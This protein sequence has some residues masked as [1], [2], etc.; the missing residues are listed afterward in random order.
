MFVPDSKPAMK[1]MKLIDTHAHVYVSEFD[2][3]RQAVMEQADKAGITRILMPAIDASTHAA[4]LQA[5]EQ[6]PGQCLSMIGL[7]P[8]SVRENFM[9]ELAIVS[10]YLTNRKWVAIGETGLDYYWDLTFREQQVQSF[11]VQIDWAREFRLPLVI[12]S[13]NSTD[14]CVEMIRKNQGGDLTGVFHCFSGDA[15]QAEAVVGLGFYL[16]I[17]G[18]LTFRNG[19]LDRALVEIPLEKIVLETDAPYL[20]PVPFRGKRNEPSYMSY[21]VRKLAELRNISEEEVAL[22]TTANAEKLFG[23]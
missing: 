3:D 19:G 12:H 21:V 22:V 18:V 13:R 16:G 7:H 1:S 10:K 15:A 23:L 2:T 4:M 20:A 9:D 11:Q 8:C 14:D 17:G 6:F 5:E